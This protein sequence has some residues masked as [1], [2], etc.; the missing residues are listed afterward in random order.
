MAGCRSTLRQR[1]A[2]RRHDGVEGPLV[3]AVEPAVRLVCS[4]SM[5][6]HIIGVVV[7]ETTSETPIATDRVTANSR[8]RR[9]TMP[10]ISSS[11]MNTATSETLM[12]TT[13]KPISCAPRRAACNG[14]HALLQIARDVLDNHDRVVHH[15]TG[16]DGQRHQRQVVDAVTA[17][18]HHAERSDQRHRNGDAGN[19]GA[20]ARFCRNTKTT[21]ITRITEMISDR[22]TSWT[23]ARITCV[24]SM[25]TSSLMDCGI[26]A[27]SCGKHGADVIHRVDDVRA[28]LAEDDHSAPTACR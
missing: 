9:P 7:S 14:L 11:G 22:S 2:V 21:R 8:N 20:Y 27:W 1:P 13:V 19:D 15:E 5:Y 25:L 23:E 28:R 26:A 6:A 12:L 10:P 4:L 16:G 24:W 3:G 18:V 17:Q